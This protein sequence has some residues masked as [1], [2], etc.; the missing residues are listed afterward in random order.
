MTN[1]LIWS[2][3]FQQASNSTEVVKK[4]FGTLEGEVQQWFN[5]I[6]GGLAGLVGLFVIAVTIVRAIKISKTENPEERKALIKSI[7]IAWGCI[8]AIILVL[9]VGNVVIEAIKQTAGGATNK[10]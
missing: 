3:L 5:I 6:V 10:S 1:K 2:E 8:A 9:I 7:A 4:A